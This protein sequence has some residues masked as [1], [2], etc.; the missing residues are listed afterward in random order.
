MLRH[1]RRFLSEQALIDWVFGLAFGAVVAAAA[2][3]LALVFGRFMP[4][5][6][7]VLRGL[8]AGYAGAFLVI[9]I[10]WLVDAIDTG[11]AK[12]DALGSF[13]LGTL[14]FG[15]VFG[16]PVAYAISAI[17]DRWRGPVIDPGIFE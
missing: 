2:G 1:V 11:A 13:A 4:H 16:F 5:A 17:H 10:V 15:T 12:F 14:I 9:M 8:R 7:P 3:L 6:G